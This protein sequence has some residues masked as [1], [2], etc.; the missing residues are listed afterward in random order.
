MKVIGLTGPSG[1][2]KG[3]VASFFEYHNI[4]TKIVNGNYFLILAYCDCFV[5]A[6]MLYC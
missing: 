4:N 2:G 5:N 6:A 1:S 3:I